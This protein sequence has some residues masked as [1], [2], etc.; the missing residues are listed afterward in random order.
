MYPSAHARGGYFKSTGIYW[1][2][3]GGCCSQCLLMCQLELLVVVSGA[4][5]VVAV[6]ILPDPLASG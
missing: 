5:E 4:A 2:V 1:L 3:G 6:V